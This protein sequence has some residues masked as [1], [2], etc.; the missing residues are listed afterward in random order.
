MIRTQLTDVLNDT[1]K[2]ALSNVHTATIAIVTAVNTNTINVKPVINRQVNGRSI[3]LPE[4]IDVPVLVMQGGTSSL[5]FPIAVGDYCVV[6]LTER[7][8]DRWFDG[9]NFVS[10]PELRMFDYSDG[11]AL[12]GVNPRANLKTIPADTTLEGDFIINGNLDIVGD[13]DVTGTIHATG[14]ITSDDDVI[15]GVISLKN[16]THPFVGVAVGVLSATQAPT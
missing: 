8:F 4:F 2:E 9:Q 7:C 1:I 3:E 14:T 10:P 13:L 11:I 5:T 6:L 16:H 15:A 12:V